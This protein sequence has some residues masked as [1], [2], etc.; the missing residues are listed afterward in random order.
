MAHTREAEDDLR[1]IRQLMDAG[2]RGRPIG[3]EVLVVLGALLA[4]VCALGGLTAFGFLPL[5]VAP[6][7]LAATSA[8]LAFVVLAV[9]N[10]DTRR[11]G[12]PGVLLACLVA[13]TA[14]ELLWRGVAY[15]S[16]ANAT[17][18]GHA[19]KGIVA[20]MSGLLAFA[21]L[22]GLFSG[23][24]LALRRL[25]RDPAARSPAN[26]MVTGGWMVVLAAFAI[27]LAV[28]TVGGLRT[29]NWVALAFIPSLFWVLWGVGWWISAQATGRRWM[30]LVVA[31]SWIAALWF[32]SGAE[33]YSSATIAFVM[34]AVLPGLKLLGDARQ[35]ADEA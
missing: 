28:D 27:V 26:R 1:R 5:A 21:V 17:H 11:L 29:G 12:T 20:V 22:A 23:A 31:G 32:V 35:A 33:I 9:G 30:L 25:R 2:H 6:S 34:L 16:R 13:G 8:F 4:I 24:A 18:D 7:P 19:D 3:G 14:G 15:L 10:G